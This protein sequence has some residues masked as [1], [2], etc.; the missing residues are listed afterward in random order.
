MEKD[1][2]DLLSRTDLSERVIFRIVQ[3][4]RQSFAI[5]GK[6]LVS[7]AHRFTKRDLP[8]DSNLFVIT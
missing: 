5:S 6:Q 3:I 7:L 8:T 1:P 2:R 4:D